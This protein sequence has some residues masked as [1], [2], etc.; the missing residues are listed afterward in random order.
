MSATCASA[1]LTPA[2][3]WDA[4][5]SYCSNGSEC[6]I[7]LFSYLRAAQCALARSRA[8]VF[9]CVCGAQVAADEAGA[10]LVA[11]PFAVHPGSSAATSRDSAPSSGRAGRGA[12]P[13]RTRR[14]SASTTSLP[15]QVVSCYIPRDDRTLAPLI[16]CCSRRLC[17][18]A[19]VRGRRLG[20]VLAAILG[21]MAVVAAARRPGRGAAVGRGGASRQCR[22]AIIFMASRGS[23]I[24]LIYV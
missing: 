12:P 5:F 14:M 1:S 3:Q 2:Q 7:D 24:F 15:S 11:S 23:R 6:P 8:C 16:F 18:N 4:Y 20:R 9:V 10:E 22:C 13:T 17:L 21:L 19:C